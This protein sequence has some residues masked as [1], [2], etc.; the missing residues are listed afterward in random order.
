MDRIAV[1]LNKQNQMADFY[2]CVCYEIYERNEQEYSIAER[3]Q[4]PKIQPSVPSQVRENVGRLAGQMENCNVAAFGY[5]AGIPYHMFDRAGFRIFQMGEYSKMALNAVFDDL[6]SVE[7]IG[8]KREEEIKKALP[9]E[10]DIPGI[11]YLDMMKA[12][13]ANPGLSTKQ[14]LLPF[15]ESTPFLELRL[16]CAHTPL[17]LERDE[18]FTLKTKEARMECLTIINKNQC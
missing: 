3:K 8:A 14:A 10:T 16:R 5:I 11:F 9:V 1:F 18:R 7:R 2:E 12:Q 4:F 6:K 13:E 15:L 17:W